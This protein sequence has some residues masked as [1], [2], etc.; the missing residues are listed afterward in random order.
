MFVEHNSFIKRHLVVNVIINSFIHNVLIELQC[1]PGAV[2]ES[3]SACSR[4]R[5][6]TCRD[7]NG[8]IN[9]KLY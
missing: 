5:D 8:E 9:T 7:S 2:L 6:K 1:G 3:G 4:K